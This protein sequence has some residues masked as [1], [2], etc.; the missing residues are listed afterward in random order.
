[1]IAYAGMGNTLPNL[2]YYN[3]QEEFSFNK[4]YSE[5]TAELIDKEVKDLIA[6]QY[7]RA[8]RLLVEHKDG[9]AELAQLLIDREVI[10]AEDV[11]RIFGKRPWRSRTD[12]IL[13][14]NE[15][16]SDSADSSDT[17]DDEPKNAVDENAEIIRQKAIDAVVEKAKK[18]NGNETE[19]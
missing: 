16:N 1:M 10:F 12:E 3:S 5:H 18:Q 9:H 14:M 19:Q 7:D 13:A 17:T 4:P 8:K 6:D 11:E 15:E 2:C